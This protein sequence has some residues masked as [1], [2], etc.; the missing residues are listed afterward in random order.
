MSATVLYKKIFSQSGL[1]T[2]YNE[3]FGLTDTAGIDGMS[4]MQFN[5]NL[6]LHL[7][8]I[9]NKCN[10][11]TYKFTTYKAKLL[12]KG[13]DSLPRIVEK[14]TIRDRLVIRAL[15]EILDETFFE[16]TKERKLHS[17]IGKIAVDIKNLRYN[18][19][20]KLDVKN[21]YPTIDHSILLNKIETRTKNRN[22]LYLLKNCI[23]TT[24]S[25][26]KSNGKLVRDVGVPQGIS[27]ANLL[28]SIYLVNFD[29]IFSKIANIKYYRYVDDILVLCNLDSRERILN[30]LFTEIK[31]YNLQFNDGDKF[32]MASLD[33]EF[34]YLGYKFS[35][36][37]ISIRPQSIKKFRESIIR[38][39]TIDKHQHY[40]NRN[41]VEFKI[42]LRITGFIY[43]Q[44]KYGWMFFFSQT[45]KIQELFSIDHFINQ[46]LKRY[47]CESLKVKKISRVY[48]EITKK[49]N[50]TNYIP[51]FDNYS[52]EDIIELLVKLSIKFNDIEDARY[53][54]LKLIHK[55]IL[56]IEQDMSAFS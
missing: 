7:E 6:S 14:P 56:D 12:S 43:D 52:D 25:A 36:R 24:N 48:K 9:I 5:K 51:N 11:C 19:F 15:F 18:C 32:K 40:K 30:K 23:T 50:K 3:K 4:S 34:E 28:S 38:I 13:Y 44:K 1:S 21:Y 33:S 17:Q 2:L 35:N 26:Y 31:K 46:Q 20:I 41:K 42:N 27:I 29:K 39:L 53:R 45:E 49:G 8:T 55:S 47:G 37:A 16:Q 22:I 10:S 54:F